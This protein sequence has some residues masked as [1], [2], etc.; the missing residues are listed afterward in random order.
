MLNLI[1]WSISICILFRNNLF[2]KKLEL[3]FPFTLCPDSVRLLAQAQRG[4]GEVL[5]NQ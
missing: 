2:L 3:T 4:K 1:H 5:K